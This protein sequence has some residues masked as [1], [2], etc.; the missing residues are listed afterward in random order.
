DSSGEHGVGEEPD[1]EGGEDE[2][3]ARPRGRHRL[4]DHR[5]PREGAGE[6]GDEVEPDRGEHP[7]PADD[8]EGIADGA[9][10]RPAPPEQRD[11]GGRPWHDE[12]DPP[13]WSP[14]SPQLHRAV[15]GVAATPLTSS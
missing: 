4:P 11:D 13:P 7:L 5:P 10:V 6:D 2:Q 3:E 9:P 15:T 14:R 8:R 1:G 12:Q